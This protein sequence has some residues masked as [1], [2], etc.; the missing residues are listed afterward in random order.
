[1]IFIINETRNKRIKTLFNF[2]SFRHPLFVH[3]AEL[4][5]KIN[6]KCAKDAF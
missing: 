1:M 5:F 2:N 3:D 6:C 4:F